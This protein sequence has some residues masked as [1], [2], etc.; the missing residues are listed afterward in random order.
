[1]WEQVDK[2]GDLEGD[3]LDLLS[4][5]WLSKATGPASV[6][7]CSIDY[8]LQARGLK[9]RRGGG[10]RRGGFG[11]QQENAVRLAV[12]RISS[13]YLNLPAVETWEPVD[14][15]K[16]RGR[17]RRA[18]HAISD[19]AFI[20][21]TTAGQIRLD[22]S[23]DVRAFTFLPGEALGRA[24]WGGAGRQVAVMSAKV[25]RYHP[26]NERWT[27]ALGRFLSW[28]WRCNASGGN[29]VVRRRVRTVLSSIGLEPD[30]TR[31]DRTRTSLE[32]AFERLQEDGIIRVW[33]YEAWDEERAGKP[34]WLQ[35]W[36]DS[37]ILVEP[38][39]EV[40][41]HYR[42]IADRSDQHRGRERGKTR[43]QKALPTRADLG[44]RLRE[45]RLANGWSLARMG[46][47][48]GVSGR[49]VGN[50]ERGS[51]PQAEVRRRLE[52][53]LQSGT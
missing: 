40:A 13:L 26:V 15:G 21:R 3:M 50:Y 4:D 19:R 30:P 14:A 11:E 41:E 36:L 49:A 9:P 28:L 1:M 24:L 45:R 48:L 38:P 37:V 2:M 20:I 5:L 33:Q 10:G 17:R 52:A 6:V 35:T 29:P 47:E 43:P 27:K 31:P 18:V 16:T 53:W 25:V 46:E 34:G 12:G 23:T 51:P 32:K 7:S 8:L 22:G 44:E 42:A 39:E